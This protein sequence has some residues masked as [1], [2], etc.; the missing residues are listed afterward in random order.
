[1]PKVITTCTTFTVS[2]DELSALLASA[3]PEF[4]KLK[5]TCNIVEVEY[6]YDNELEFNFAPRDNF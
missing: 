5:K 2:D 6:N 3:Y 4:A 1:M